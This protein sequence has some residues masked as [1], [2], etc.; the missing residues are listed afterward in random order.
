MDM[1]RY[2]LG[3]QLGRGGQATIYEGSR[4][5][6][7]G[8]EQPVAFKRI[9]TELQRM[10]YFVDRF[11][12]EARLGLD[13]AHPNVIR[14]YDFDV[15][16][17]GPLM[18]ME[19]IEGPTIQDVRDDL[20]VRYGL[21]RRILGEALQGLDY[22]HRH[23]IIHRDLTPVNILLS[24]GGAVKIIDLGLAKDPDM[25]IT[26]VAVGTTP[27]VSPEQLRGLPLDPSTDLYALAA[28]AYEVL[29]GAPPFGR[30]DRHL[31][32]SRQN[33][34]GAW[35]IAPLPDEVPDDL[36]QVVMGLLQPVET[37]TFRSAQ[38]VLEVLLQHQQPVASV[39]ELAMFALK[40]LVKRDEQGED[41]KDLDELPQFDR[42]K[43]PLPPGRAWFPWRWPLVALML[44]G[45]IGGGMVLGDRYVAWQS[46]TQ[47][48]KRS[49]ASVVFQPIHPRTVTT[50]GAQ[51]P[52]PPTATP[53]KQASATTA[54]LTRDPA[55]PPSQLDAPSSTD[56]FVKDVRP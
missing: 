41:T 1:N 7:D 11:H 18:V 23:G 47:D 51:E 22:L 16:E 14:V 9:H 52:V 35:R 6:A 38:D 55:V 26:N 46:S 43:L 27:Y 5:L 28:V 20:K 24:R 15:T 45:C 37:R 39:T 3:K 33:A 50:D 2:R 49:D 56:F 48:A 44:L 4:R 8:T 10:H 17:K 25:P 31:I 19:R 54:R 40:G 36:R 30:G 34:D 32:A 29:T 42:G 13:L 12:Q 53:T 21:L